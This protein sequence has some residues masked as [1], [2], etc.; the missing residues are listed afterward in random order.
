MRA[1]TAASL[2]EL[3]GSHASL[4]YHNEAVRAL[5]WEVKYRRSPHAIALAGEFLCEQVLAIAE[6]E[7][8][9]VILVP[10]P[11][12][13]AR[14]KARGYNQT[15][16]LCEAILREAPDS[17]D[18]APHALARTRATLPQQGLAR[19]R[20][21]T[22]V[23]GSMEAL[24]EERVRGRACVVV[25]DVSTTG[26]TLAEASRALYAAGARSVHSVILSQS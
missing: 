19:E 5:V 8:G 20:R 2:L 18:Y 11:M 24:Q 9:K 14:R 4:P 17:F 12:H 21:L 13:S 22:N 26:A 10:A 3:A 23:R 16:L 6:E 1:Q 7:L 25:D 15:E